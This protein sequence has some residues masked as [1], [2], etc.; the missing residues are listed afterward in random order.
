MKQQLITFFTLFIV[1]ITA[2]Y[3]QYT[4]T[5]TIKAFDEL[6]V[7]GPFDIELVEDQNNQL[8]IESEEIDLH[9]IVTEVDGTTLKIRSAAAFTKQKKIKITVH[10]DVLREITSS[11]GA[12]VF[13][14]R[15][16][17]GD[18]LELTAN[19]GGRME[20]VVDVEKVELK[21]S[22]GAEVRIDGQ[23]KSADFNCTTGAQ[24]YAALLSSKEVF[25]EV[26]T[27]GV[28][29]VNATK[30]LDAHATTKGEV[31]YVGDPEVLIDDV[32]LKGI[33]KKKG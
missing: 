30:R 2:T 9:K 17:Y 6:R 24:I 21:A 18:K 32:K 11:A 12:I 22:Q 1:C 13:S 7:T 20:F 25:V 28:A 16:I 4:E 29:E 26:S 23:S 31:L 33:I 10:Y 3:G 5:R 15:T 27:G 19:A 14:D 8:I